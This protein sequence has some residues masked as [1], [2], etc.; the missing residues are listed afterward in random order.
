AI[1]HLEKA[2]SFTKNRYEKIRWSFILAQ[3]QEL[4][5]N[6]E[7][8]YR[9]YSRVVK[10]NASFEMSFNANLAQ[11]RLRETAGG[12]K[13]NKIATLTKLLKEDKNKEFKDQ[14]Y[15][16]IAK[17]YEQQGDLNVAIEFYQTSAHEASGSVK[18]RGL[19]YL[20]LAEINFD[21]LKN[22]VQAQLY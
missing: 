16:Q 22:Y 13:F 11:I 4:N 14:I 12:V 7:A 8:A 2:I 9:N 21:S 15:Y 5:N 1:E 10:S 17:T 20:R 18:Q 19:S 6:E 3:L